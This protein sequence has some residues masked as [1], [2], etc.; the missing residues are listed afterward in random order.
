MT[1]PTIDP[2]TVQ[3]VDFGDR[4]ERRRRVLRAL[5]LVITVVLAAGVAWLVWFSPVLSVKGVRVVGV[6]GEQANA[7]LAAAQVPLGVQ[8]ARVN[9]DGATA[10][11]LS[12]PWVSSAEVRR[13]WPTEVVIAVE[14]RTAIAV[15]SVSGRGID[16]AGVVFDAS[17]ALA[18]TLPSVAAT[19]VGLT[20]AMAVIAALP[21]DLAPRVARVSATSRDDVDLVLHSGAK[22][23]WGSADQPEL[24]AQVLRALMKQK[25]DVYDVTAPELPTTFSAP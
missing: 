6:V 13:G 25:Q 17:T 2:V 23:H 18:K 12:L 21:A 24:K 16:A 4:S 11:V 9:A 15:D 20:E 19:G 3:R 7:V 14:A 1:A 22:V 5:A 10:A 8:L